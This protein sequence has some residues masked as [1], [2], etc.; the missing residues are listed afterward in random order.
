M[1][2]ST[3]NSR[4]AAMPLHCCCCI[5]SSARAAWPKRSTTTARAKE[6]VVEAAT[7][8]RGARARAAARAAPRRRRRR[9]RQAAGLER[10]RA[11]FVADLLGAEPRVR[12]GS[13]PTARACS[14]SA[15]APRATPRCATRRRRTSRWSTTSRPR[16]GR[17]GACSIMSGP[18]GAVV[19]VAGRDVRKSLAAAGAPARR[20]AHGSASTARA[21]ARPGPLRARRAARRALLR[22]AAAA[23]PRI[24]VDG[25]RAALRADGDD[26]LPELHG[27][28]DARREPVRGP[29]RRAPARAA[30]RGRPG[31]RARRGARGDRRRARAGRASSVYEIVTRVDRSRGGQPRRN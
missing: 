27:A 29:L 22:G 26:V 9:R 25:R 10:R 4:W 15:R 1:P 12:R 17:E 2:A 21:P 3:Q 19:R 5:S 18:A 28:A 30:A 24:A 7:P 11:A 16:R 8:R 14:A 23:G 6:T 13:T 31:A 20:R